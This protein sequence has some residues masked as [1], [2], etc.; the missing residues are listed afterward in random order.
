M[1]RNYIGCDYI[2][3]M[4][5]HD[6]KR[7]YR[8]DKDKGLEVLENAYQLGVVD[9]HRYNLIKKAYELGLK[10]EY[11]RTDG[12]EMIYFDWTIKVSGEVEN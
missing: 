3:P 1:F 8:K 9:T 7:N 11:E 10:V 5:G 6:S 2:A 4:P 12:S